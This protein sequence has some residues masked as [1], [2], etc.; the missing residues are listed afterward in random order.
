M[1]FY[2]YIAMILIYGGAA[3][4]ANA[5]TIDPVV[6]CGAGKVDCAALNVPPGPS[7]PASEILNIESAFSVTPGI[8]SLLY[9]ND[10]DDG[11]EE[12]APYDPWYETTYSNTPSDPSGATIS[13]QGVGTDP[14][15][16]CPECYL[17]VKDGRQDPN[18]YIFNLGTLVDLA[19]WNGT[20]DLVLENFWPAQGAIS[21]VAIYGVSV[22]PVPATF[23]LF[24]TALLG[25]IGISRRTRV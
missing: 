25:F 10:V 7:N 18:V 21:H 14:S 5:L 6:D 24:G 22:I 23:W 1:K 16:S 13:W 3:F 9:K 20:D 11:E 19:R 12:G 8:L 2:K 4:N 15:I 17:Y